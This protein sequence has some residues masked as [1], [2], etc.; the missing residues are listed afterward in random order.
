MLMYVPYTLRFFEIILPNLS[1]SI[2][3]SE[4]PVVLRLLDRI[5]KRFGLLSS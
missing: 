4:L 5:L 2:N 3:K 1:H